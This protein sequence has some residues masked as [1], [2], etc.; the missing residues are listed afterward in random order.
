M[1]KIILIALAASVDC[2]AVGITYRTEEIVVSW[3]TKVIICV[4]SSLTALAAVVL[5]NVMEYFINAHD[6]QMVG[7]VVLFFL[8]I[9]SLWG[10]YTKREDKNYD[11]DCSK[12]IDLLEGVMLGVVMASDA[13]CGGLSLCTMGWEVYSYPVLVG[14]FTYLFFFLSSK[15]IPFAR[16]SGYL[17]GILLVLIGVAQFLGAFAG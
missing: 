16:F 1:F 7:A 14:G 12:S 9:H 5:G 3:Y 11:V 6:V 2:L 15:K 13:F 8:G 10:M 17:A 4:V